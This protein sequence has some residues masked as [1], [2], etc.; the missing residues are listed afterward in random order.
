MSEEVRNEIINL[1]CSKLFKKANSNHFK[2]MLSRNRYDIGIMGKIK[3]IMS[4]IITHYPRQNLI[5]CSGCSL[6]WP[7]RKAI[8]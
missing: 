7:Y 4:N 5:R 8:Y 3:K 6:A 1:E 2:E